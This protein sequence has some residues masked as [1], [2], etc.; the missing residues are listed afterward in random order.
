[1]HLGSEGVHRRRAMHALAESRRWDGN[2][3][4]CHFSATGNQ[5]NRCTTSA[6]FSSLLMAR[7]LPPSH[8]GA[9]LVYGGGTCHRSCPARMSLVTGSLRPTVGPLRASR[10]APLYTSYTIGRGSVNTSRTRRTRIPH[11]TARGRKILTAQKGDMFVT[12]WRWRSRKP[13]VP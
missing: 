12:A 5:R 10:E 4:G 3:R 8:D 1:M 6:M 7:L 9:T 13:Y 2:T 11:C